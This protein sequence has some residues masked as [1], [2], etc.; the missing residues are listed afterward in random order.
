VSSRD[1]ILADIRRALSAGLASKGCSS[2]HH[3]DPGPH[4]PVVET[5]ARP[6]L[7]EFRARFESAGGRWHESRQAVLEIVKEI[8]ARRALITLNDPPL[9]Q[10]LRG[11]V[12]LVRKFE[13]AQADTLDVMITGVDCA[14]ADTGSFGVFAK[15][16]AGRLT[17]LI[18]PVHIAIVRPGQ[19]VP[20]LEDFLEL[21]RPHLRDWSAAYLIT[22]PSRTGDIEQVLT[23]GVH[24]PG[25]LDAVL[26]SEGA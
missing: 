11:Q 3:D 12:E 23:I 13:R 24:G 6:I 20:R 17:T 8:G 25:R 21:V 4:W 16:G 10:L 19:F 14:I 1:A 15:P 18:A 5:P 7:E 9:E 26:V 2:P 22:G